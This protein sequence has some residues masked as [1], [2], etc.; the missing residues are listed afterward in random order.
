MSPAA[1]VAPLRTLPT[2]RRGRDAAAAPAPAQG[3]PA[4]APAYVQLIPA[5]SN[6]LTLAPAGAVNTAIRGGVFVG[7]RLDAQHAQHGAVPAQP[8]HHPTQ[9]S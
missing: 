4:C 1:G 8:P 7:R 2:A 3:A 5:G 6:R 9:P